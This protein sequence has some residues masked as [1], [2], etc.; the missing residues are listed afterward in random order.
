MTVQ[1]VD[2]THPIE[3]G[4]VT[5]PGL[6]GPQVGVHLSRDDSRGHYAEGTEFEIG[7]IAMV[8]NTGTYLDAPSHRYGTGLDLAGLPLSRTAALPGVV[9]DIRGSAS[10]G[11]PAGALAGIEVA[12]RAVLIR[13]G[14]DR[15]WRTDRYGIDAP[16]L[17]REASRL[18]A[19]RAAVLV[20]IDAVNIDDVNDLQRPA[21]SILLAAGIPVLEH[22]TGLDALP[23]NGFTLHAAPIPVRG[24]GTTPVRAYAVIP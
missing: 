22:L 10:R 5:Y 8:G 12:G 23:P 6:P 19:D 4:M 7:R 9:V 17:T 24:L 1:L 18:L 2:L 16:F 13:T 14:W 15:Y 20:G 21:H 3:N 11:V